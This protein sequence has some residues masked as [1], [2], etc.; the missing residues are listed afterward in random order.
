MVTVENLTFKP[1]L[2]IPAKATH[3]KCCCCGRKA[4]VAAGQYRAE[5]VISEGATYHFNA[6]SRSC[7]A[8]FFMT[9]REYYN[10]YIRRELGNVAAK[11]FGDNKAALLT[12][13]KTLTE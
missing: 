6:C 3:F 10:A 11:H 5:Y 13:I 2:I 9:N 8:K 1:I 7:V 12:F 4:R